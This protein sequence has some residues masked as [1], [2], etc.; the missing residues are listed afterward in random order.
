MFF[1]SLQ[2]WPPQLIKKKHKAAKKKICTQKK[3]K[4][5]INGRRKVLINITQKIN[6]LVMSITLNTAPHHI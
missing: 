1:F 5:A 4:V 6:N 2:R 3:S